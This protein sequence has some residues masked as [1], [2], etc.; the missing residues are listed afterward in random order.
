MPVPASRPSGPRHTLRVVLT[1]PGRPWLGF[2]TLVS[3]AIH[4]VLLG[5]VVLAYQG[6]PQRRVSI[7]EFV[8]FLVPPDEKAGVES[9]RDVPWSDIEG[10]GTG[11]TGAGAETSIVGPEQAIRPLSDSAGPAPSIGQI[12]QLGDSVLT[13]LQVDSTV[14]RFAESAAPEYPAAL[15][16]KN[17]E[18]N[19][20]VSFIVDTTGY[21][22]LTSFQVIEASHPEFAM[23]VRRAL[24]DMR[25][26]AAILANEKVRQLVQQ[27]F[28]F[29][30]QRPADSVPPGTGN[31]QKPA[32]D[33]ER[34]TS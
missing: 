28:V 3:L 19:A 26:R 21:A 18:G 31:M 8:T 16:A 29:Q 11:G 10:T 25:F 4:A 14:R 15:L 34:G 1:P 6:R 24:P 9:S 22:D 2:S 17:I 27:N 13:E 7:D 20:L 30:I 33:P 12:P 23:A 5:L 32:L